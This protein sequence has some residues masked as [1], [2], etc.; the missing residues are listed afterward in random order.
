[1]AA[2]IIVVT[3]I[4]GS[5][6][7]EFCEK[8]KPEGKKVK[9]YKTGEMVYD[10]AQ[11][12]PTS[13]P[14]P[15]ENLLNLPPEVMAYLIREAFGKILSNLEEDRKNYDRI[16]IDTHAQF[17]WDHIFHN[18]FDWDHLEGIP[19]DLFITIIDKP[20]S[21]SKAQAKKG[22]GHSQ[23]NDYRDL[24]LWQNVEVNTTQG[25]ASRFRK[26][27]YVLSRMQNPAVIDSLLDNWF[28]IYA[29]FPMTDADE[30]T[31][32]K[33]NRFKERL[34]NLR[35]EIDGKE[36]PI[37]DPADIDVEE[38]KILGEKVLDAINTHTVHRDLYWD[39]RQA[40]HVI[41]I[42]PD[43]KSPLSKGVSDEDTK[44]ML[45][46]KFVT[47]IY[48]KTRR[49]PFMDIA[50]EV[51]TNEEEFFEYFKKKMTEDLERFKR[52]NDSNENE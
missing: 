35:K 22:D 52:K 44:A 32:A 11:D 19:V 39:I 9:I 50:H 51:F 34:R 2:K 23:R 28:F 40:T 42:Y 46:G 29:S 25:W 36:T 37:I 41:S 33:I 7:K 8:Y 14:I 17:F 10:L 3:G 12:D 13:P 49:S 5:G 15:S 18:A 16:I 24:L 38:D 26:P 48:P 45:T 47:V 1:M 6:S 20:S 4:S 30:E 27:M 21:I 31:T 43:E